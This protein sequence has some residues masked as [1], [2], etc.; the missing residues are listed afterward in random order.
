MQIVFSKLKIMATSKEELFRK[1]K[2]PV[3]GNMSEMSLP[4]S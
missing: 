3:F 2:V 4:L 1:G